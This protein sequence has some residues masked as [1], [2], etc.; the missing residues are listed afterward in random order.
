MAK[1]VQNNSEE[2]QS[3]ISWLLTESNVKVPIEVFPNMHV[4]AKASARS[5]GVSIC[6]TFHSISIHTRMIRLLERN[7]YFGRINVCNFFKRQN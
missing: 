6:V 4:T 7:D 2:A 5:E 3:I 1:L